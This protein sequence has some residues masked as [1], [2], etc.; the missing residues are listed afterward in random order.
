MH[1]I[2]APSNLGLRSLRPWHI[3]GAWRAP[4]ALLVDM[5]AAMFQQPEA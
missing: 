4:Q 3:P 5:L 1:L 2:L